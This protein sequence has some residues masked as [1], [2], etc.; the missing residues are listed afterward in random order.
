MIR[1]IL[2]LIST[3]TRAQ[4]GSRAVCISPKRAIAKRI[5]SPIT[6]LLARFDLASL[7]NLAGAGLFALPFLSVSQA[8]AATLS[9]DVT[10]YAIG[11][12]ACAKPQNPRQARCF[13]MRRQMVETTK[14]GARPFKIAGGARTADSIG[15]A[16]G[17]TPSDLASAYNLPTTGGAGQTVAVVDAYNAPTIES[18]LQVFDAQYGL[19]TCTIANGC[20]KVVSQT[21]STT[22]LPPNDTTGWSTEATLDVQTVHAV[23]QGCKIILVEANTQNLSDMD[24]AEN[25]AVKLGAT[26]ISNSFGYPESTAVTADFNS[27]NHSGVVITASTGDDGYYDFDTLSGYN[28]AN[29]P[30]SS[31]YVIA[32]G[33]TSL[34]LNQTGGRQSETVWNDNGVKGYYE[35]LLGQPLG[36]GG[37]GC[38]TRYPAFPWQVRSTG[39]SATGC[40]T[41]RM[42]ADVAAVADYLTGLDI[43]PSY[44]CGGSCP[45]GWLTIGGTSLSSPLVAAV[46]ALAG[47][48][49]GV[50]YPALTLYGHPGKTYNVTAGGNGWCD[51]EGAAECG[52][53]NTL[54]VG[55]LDCDFPASGSTPTSGDTACD[56]VAGLNGPT[57]VG[58]PNGITMFTK[59]GPLAP[60]AGPIAVGLGVSGTW[61][62]HASDPFPGGTVTQYVW[63]WG[64]GTTTTTTTQSATHTYAATGTFTINLTVTDRYG[65]TG[66]TTNNYSVTVS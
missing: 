9:A 22:K 58:T 37:G 66:V 18:D 2:A 5:V 62:C 20:L 27:F 51:G 1:N 48:A 19:T 24:A 13:A 36:A 35:L 43:Y 29:F 26:E 64:D 49:N 8:P 6:D 39:W 46:Y 7:R 41:M 10:Y 23:C 17:L 57:G 52:D 25:E 47:G 16:G 28:Q 61:T 31:P 44:P 21:G 53:P 34:Y 4:S 60:L 65:V 40:G 15:P 3:A 33:G 42:A 54:G 38:S 32:V 56:A 50:P 14:L 45:T 59:T 55:I 63:N 11:A 30:A 12:P